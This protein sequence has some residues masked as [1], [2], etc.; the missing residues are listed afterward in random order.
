MDNE[1]LEEVARGFCSGF[2][3]V[4]MWIAEVVV[5]ILV[6]QRIR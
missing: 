5:P 6:W 3:R 1:V 2:Y 4:S